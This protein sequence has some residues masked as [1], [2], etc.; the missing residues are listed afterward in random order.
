MTQ[1]LETLTGL[2]ERI[3]F[4]NEETGFCVLKIKVKENKDLITL[5]GIL[6]T[7]RT[8][9]WVEAQGSWI[10]DKQYGQQFKSQQMH[11]TPP[12]S[13][14]GMEKYLASGLIK[15]IGPVYAKKL[16]QTFGEKVFEI[17]ETN[18]D[19]LKA[20][21][22]LGSHKRQQ[23]IK[24]WANQKAV[25][26][27]MLFLHSHGVSTNRAIRIYK[28]Y[29][30]QAI[31]MIQ[32][33]PYRLAQDI[34]GIGFINADR[35]AERLGIDS[36]SLIRARAGLSYI[37]LKAMEEGHCG[38]PISLL[39]PSA[40]SLLN[41]N[42]QILEQALNLEIKAGIIVQDF[43]QDTVCVFLYGL[44]QAEK[45]IAEILYNLQSASVPWP[46]IE[47]QQAILK[48]E[49]KNNITLSPSQKEALI[50]T[51][52]NKVTIITGGPGVGK[53]TLLRSILQIFKAQKMRL[54]L[55]A[56]TG[57]AAKRM[58]E[59]T[60][61]EAKTIHRLLNLNPEAG[62]F[63]RSEGKVLESDVIVVDEV[64]MVDI[65]LFYTLLKAIPPQATLILVGD[66]DQLPSVGPGQVLAD[67]IASNA[68]PFIHLTEPF[69]Q[70][71][72]SKIIAV[73]QSINNG[74][75]PP[76][77][78]YGPDSDFFFI[79]EE[80]P[81]L[82]MQTIV[83]LVQRRLPDKLGYSPL[84]DIQV[85]CPMT[86]G[87]V[88]TRMLNIELQKALNPP[89]ATSIQ[90]FGSWYSVGDKVMQIEN[91]YQKEVYNGDI[92]FIQEIDVEEN[93]LLINFD[94][95]NTVYEF[96]ELDE[97]ILAYAMTIHKSQGSEYPVV[98]I[99]LVSQHHLMLQKNLIYTGITRGKKLV[100]LVGQ[101]T[102]LLTAIHNKKTLRR[103]SMLEER[104]KFGAV[105]KQAFNSKD[106][107]I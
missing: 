17:I 16:V 39:L 15:G 87:V 26:A 20:I 98:I 31:Q 47:P 22:G 23:I 33:N 2:I 70:A 93:Q 83:E 89:G 101:K 76:L 90:K 81:S 74:I 1:I 30:D 62:S 34:R 35:I 24:G 6:P 77:K 53:T 107:H 50:K 102:A 73:A 10:Q 52:S 18:P 25:R 88:G 66:Q 57:R 28:T 75:V 45:G 60:G 36:E 14:D 49:E 63:T 42:Q 44:H 64:S 65:P 79:T 92:G 40:Q 67:L 105:K 96:H 68:L 56:P 41:I 8:G 37:L 84:H 94:G 21:P 91:N 95:K 80:N 27:I 46:Q 55:C 69:R 106:Q 97:I 32:E 19:A 38:L 59:A 71:A 43:V 82:T 48:V 100:I 86:K 58:A 99:P 13:L 103:W 54:A 104:L 7:V 11:L 72:A 29:G 4:H 9:E 61:C 3:T 85:L 5:I 78:G 12:A 51:L